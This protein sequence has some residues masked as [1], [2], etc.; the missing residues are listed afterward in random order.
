MDKH[1]VVGA[2][3]NL[4]CG[5]VPIDGYAN[6][7][8]KTGVRAYPLDV[9]DGSLS[10]VRASHLLEHYPYREL[11]E[12]LV[13]WVS[14]LKP[15]GILKI[16][17]PDLNKLIDSY[18]SGNA[19]MMN[20]FLM[21]GQGDEHDYHKSVIDEGGL[22]RAFEDCGLVDIREWKSD[23]LDCS[24]LE[25]SLNLQGTKPFD[26]L[27]VCTGPKVSA[28]MSMPRLTFSSNAACA[29]KV[30]ESMQIEANL[31]EGVFWD[32]CL[33]RAIEQAIDKHAEYIITLD[34]DTWFEQEHVMRLLQLMAEHPE[35]D[36]IV[37][38]Q[39]MRDRGNAMFGI[40]DGDGKRVTVHDRE[41]FLQPV[42]QIATGH[43]GLTIF[44]AASLAKAEKPWFLAVPDEKGGWGEGRQD[45]DIAFWNK[46]TKQGFVTYLANDVF[47]GHLQ[48]VC[49]F[50]NKVT[51]ETPFEPIHCYVADVRRGQYPEHCK[52]IIELRK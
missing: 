46:W 7:D 34:Y 29:S 3:V 18:R 42:T 4:G 31:S 24:A 39:N 2:K 51:S 23:A 12:V 9:P 47:I 19:D 28:V 43:F 10:E 32:Q 13:N 41:K 37:P 17:V 33:T 21:G 52:P 50:A 11:G 30:F 36:A 38:I 44:R 1:E 5:D 49:T 35:A 48:L 15:G 6:I 22:R 8:I 14:K 27:P 16:A 26:A 20:M 40:V 45:A 25:I